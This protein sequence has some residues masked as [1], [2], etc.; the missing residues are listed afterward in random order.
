MFRL[1]IL[2]LTAYVLWNLFKFVLM[3]YKAYKAA[4]IELN[5]RPSNSVVEKDITGKVRI[6]EGDSSDGR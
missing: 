1:I 5:F 3:V 2:G 4:D 6:V